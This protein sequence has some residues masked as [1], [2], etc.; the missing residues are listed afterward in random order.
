MSVNAIRRNSAQWR[1]HGI[2]CAERMPHES[3]A[4]SATPA[5]AGAPVRV[6]VVD[7]H[8]L[9]RSGLRRLLQA[10]PELEVVADARSGEEAVRLAG[11]LR[12]DVVV[13]DHRMGGISG[14][15]A[16]RGI[17]AGS[18]GT[19]VLMLTISD[20]DDD[21]LD[22]IVAGAAGYLLKD[23]SLQEI[24]D[25]IRA[26]ARG[27]S[28]IAPRVAASL[29]ARL[30]RQT[31]RSGAPPASFDLSPRE[32]DVLRLLVHGR[33]NI[34]IARQLHL[35]PSTIKHHVASIVE[36]LDVENRTQAAVLAV[37]QELVDV[38]S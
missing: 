38:D 20:A 30:R 14:P 25:A 26:A 21:V 2:E 19:A 3:P 29:L 16:T 35:S 6:V 11:G 36:K 34:A 24:V 13:M 8:D 28:M 7:D 27:E 5:A 31:P 9:F 23:A 12:P 1:A 22:A 4:G 33:D 18:P 10:E 37:R 32:L 17:L 15:E